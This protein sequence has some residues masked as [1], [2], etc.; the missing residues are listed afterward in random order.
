MLSGK[1]LIAAGSLALYVS[2]AA[3]SVRETAEKPKCRAPEERCIG[4]AYKPT[5]EWIPCCEGSCDTPH[6][7]WGTMCTP[8]E[9]QVAPTPVA[10]TPKCKN[11]PKCLGKDK[12]CG[13]AHEL[14]CCDKLECLAGLGA[15]DKV[16]YQC[17]TPP[18]PCTAE[19]EVCGDGLD[20][21]CEGCSPLSMMVCE[22]K[23]E[24]KQVGYGSE[25]TCTAK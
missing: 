24:C 5:V 15:A 21:C 14:S 8:K 18:P 17:R 1:L 11:G 12:E 22:P 10:P 4:A 9:T 25:K 20:A 6:P 7:D 16:V 23:F 19:G 2:A 13:D 3:P